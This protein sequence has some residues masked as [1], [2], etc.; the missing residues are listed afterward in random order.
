[1]VSQCY[2]VSVNT[3]ASSMS[4]DSVVTPRAPLVSS[5]SWQ[6][7]RKRQAPPWAVILGTASQS[8]WSQRCREWYGPWQWSRSSLQPQTPE[9]DEAFVAFSAPFLC[10]TG[11]WSLHLLNLKEQQI[12]HLSGMH[13]FLS[14][15]NTSHMDQ[16][17]NSNLPSLTAIDVSYKDITALNKKKRI[18]NNPPCRRKTC[19]S[20]KWFISA[21]WLEEC[22]CPWACYSSCCNPLLPPMMRRGSGIESIQVLPRE[23]NDVIWSEEEHVYWHCQC[24]LRVSPTE[25]HNY[26]LMI[27]KLSKIDMNSYCYLHPV[28]KRP[29]ILSFTLFQEQFRIK[30]LLLCC[31]HWKSIDLEKAQYERKDKKTSVS[32]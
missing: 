12:E 22:T 20:R 24:S 27:T 25:R 16:R 3:Q 31:H 5:L 29:F 21:E 10:K 28:K 14:N 4:R 26:L 23:N 18:Q 8:V 32:C 11:T 1:M 7:W 19:L 6:V 30:C 15:K 2:G 9:P 13:H 17:W